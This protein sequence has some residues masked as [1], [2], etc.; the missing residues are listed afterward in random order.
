[1]DNDVLLLIAKELQQYNNI[2][3]QEL[4]TLRKFYNDNHCTSCKKQ[5]NSIISR[6]NNE[7]RRY[8]CKDCKN[9]YCYDCSYDIFYCGNISCNGYG[10]CEY[11][12]NTICDYNHDI[13]CGDQQNNQHICKCVVICDSCE[14]KK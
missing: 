7:T 11:C 3:K 14:A 2:K 9:I 5:V 12:N 8:N 6:Y 4:E 13:M 10:M 1:M